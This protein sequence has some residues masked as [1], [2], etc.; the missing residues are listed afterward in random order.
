[1][2]DFIRHGLQDYIEKVQCDTYLVFLEQKLVAL[3]TL[4]EDQLILDDDEKE[5]DHHFAVDL[6]IGIQFKDKFYIGYGFGKLTGEPAGMSH[7][8]HMVRLGLS[9]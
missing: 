4:K 2:D 9:F 6:T 7:S 1:M 8:D 5:I 3:L